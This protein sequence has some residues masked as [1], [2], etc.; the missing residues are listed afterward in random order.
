MNLLSLPF[1]VAEIE[2]Q[3]NQQRKGHTNSGPQCPSALALLQG[4]LLLKVVCRGLPREFAHLHGTVAVA[5]LLVVNGVETVVFDRCLII[6]THTGQLC[7]Q[8]E[9]GALQS[10]VG[11]LGRHTEALLGTRII[12]AVNSYTAQAIEGLALPGGIFQGGKQ[13][14]EHAVGFI[15]LSLL[16]QECGIL[17]P[18]A[19]RFTLSKKAGLGEHTLII[20]LGTVGLMKQSVTGGDVLQHPH[21]M[22]G[23]AGKNLV[24]IGTAIA[25]QRPFVKPLS[26]IDIAQPFERHTHETGS[27]HR[28]ERLTGFQQRSGSTF[29]IAPKLTT[30]TLIEEGT[31]MIEGRTSRLFIIGHCSVDEGVA[32]HAG[33]AHTV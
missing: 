22:R 32:K 24:G 3:Q 15:N 7:Q 21:L 9:T 29:Y 10:T 19:G 13:F 4:V 2:E 5:H 6:L 28:R 25:L 16:L 23:F 27:L 8:T 17:Q 12:P 33:L 20:D 18:D 14:G 31:S 26:I 1:A 11:T 30:D